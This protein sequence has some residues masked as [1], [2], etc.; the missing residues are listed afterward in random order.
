MQLGYDENFSG[1]I[2]LEAATREKDELGRKSHDNSSFPSHG[3]VYPPR[4]S[5]GVR[6]LLFAFGLSL[7][8]EVL[9]SPFYAGT[10]EASWGRLVY[11]RMHG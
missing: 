10:F 6:I 5:A 9:Q 3:E 2:S 11:N 7:V 1:G 4:R 8:W